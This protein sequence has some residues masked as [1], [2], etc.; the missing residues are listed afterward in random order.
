MSA[1]TRVA[2]ISIA[3][4]KSLGLQHPAEVALTEAGVAEDRRFYLVDHAGRLVDRLVAGPLVRVGAWTDPTAT[5]LR[6]ELPDGTVL[7][8]EVRLGEAV[9]HAIYDRIADGHVVEGPWAAA[10][11]P[12]AGRPVRLVRCDRPGGTRDGDQVSLV[13]D[14]SLRELAAHAERWD[15][16]ARRFRMLFEIEGA[17]AHEEDTWIGRSVAIGAAT[18]RITEPDARCAITTQDPDTGLRDLDTLRLIIGY[19]GLG[20]R[21]KADFGVLGVVESPGTVR[22]GDPVTVR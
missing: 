9:T 7:D 15:V 20:A 19:R 10:I 5:R 18:V 1:R 3:P 21:R 8:D 16:D 11:E 12:F 2:R 22:V 6:L 13:S 17:A 14:G 4:V